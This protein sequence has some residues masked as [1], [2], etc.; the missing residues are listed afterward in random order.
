MADSGSTYVDDR[1]VPLVSSL[2][3]LE[4]LVLDLGVGSDCSSH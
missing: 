2:A 4:F 1:P 3:D